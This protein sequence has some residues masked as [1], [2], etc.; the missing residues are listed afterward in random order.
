MSA[1][2]VVHSDY[3]YILISIVN[4]MEN[5]WMQQLACIMC[6]IVNE[7]PRALMSGLL[8]EEEAG[9]KGSSLGGGKR[10]RSYYLLLSIFS[11]PV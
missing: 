11:H 1:F 7:S 2:T 6:F 3:Y 10:T 9:E 5:L 8:E 4:D